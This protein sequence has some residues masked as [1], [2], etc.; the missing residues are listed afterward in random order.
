MGCGRWEVGWE[1]G[2][3]RKVG[4]GRREGG[5]RWGGGGEGEGVRRRV[6]WEGFG[7]VWCGPKVFGS[8]RYGSG[9]LDAILGENI[10]ETAMVYVYSPYFG[11]HDASRKTNNN[12]SKKPKTLN[13]NTRLL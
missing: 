13:P 8:V 7:S 11:P 12:E 5:W 9:R 10:V 2:G 3:G 6:R 4:G 1:V